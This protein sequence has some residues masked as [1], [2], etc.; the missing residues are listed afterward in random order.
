M[1]AETNAGGRWWTGR[2]A[3]IAIVALALAVFVLAVVPTLDEPLLEAHGFR[4]TQ[5]AYTARIYHQ[6]GIDLLHPKLPV[7]GEPFEVPFEFP[8]FQ[9]AA[10]VVMDVGFDDDV[11]MRLTG[12]ACFLLTAVLLYGLVRH[13]ADRPSAVAALVAFLAT[14]FALIWGRASM[15]EYL[16]TAGAVGFAWAT[17]AWRENRR[18]EIA[19]LALAAWLVGMLVKPT[20]AAFWLLP[21]L[22][23]RPTNPRST[24]RG[25]T[26]AV[27]ALL[28]FVPLAATALWTRHADA[29][30]AA[31]PLTDWLTSS[32]LEDWNFGSLS[33]RLDR[34]VWGVIVGRVVVHVL[35]FAGVALLA[36]A[37]VALV[38]SA[39]RLFWV[40]VVL[41][42]ALPPLVFTN[43]YLIHDYYIAAVTPALAALLGLGAGFIWRLLPPTP[44]VRVVAALL[45]L[46]FAASTVGLDHAY[47]RYAWNDEPDTATLALARQLDRVSR[48][49]DRIGVIGLDWSPAALYYADRW[50]LMVVDRREREALDALRSE[51]Y[52]RLL[53]RQ[54]E[55]TDLRAFARWPWIAALSENVYGVAEDL[56]ELP[57]SPVLASDGA[58]GIAPGRAL[59]RGLH[60]PC[61][62]RP[63]TIPSGPDGTLVRVSNDAPTTR[64]WASDELAP[65]PAR[66]T[67]LLSPEL[68][69][70]GSIPIRCSGPSLTVDVSEAVFPKRV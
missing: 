67:I 56:D 32:E 40:G 69:R 54:P 48:A 34:G 42:G 28:V 60:L 55:E 63:T 2:S 4:Q 46:L 3:E 31:S 5:T 38:R 13:V 57:T 33:Q 70:G 11:A 58:D 53:V 68:A 18:P 9:A 19:G 21:A 50:G 64:V 22:A 43:L 44:P 45:G 27:L 39:Q 23:Y 25:R 36:V 6:D 29:I 1:S 10:S 26:A 12:L 41:A 30:K 51:R 59:R 37:L 14:P 7:L 66:R 49:D 61:D 16:A 8:L 35:G 24:S 52:H 17:V 47:W 20:T 65:L 15:I 62:G